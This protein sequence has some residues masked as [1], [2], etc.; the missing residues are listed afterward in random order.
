MEL[1]Q[2]FGLKG[3][4]KIN[5]KVNNPTSGVDSMVEV[6]KFMKQRVLKVSNIQSVFSPEVF[7]AQMELQT[8]VV[9]SDLFPYSFFLSFINFI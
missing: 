2:V 1:E 7:S 4:A 8:K 5:V 9:L 3:T 6:L